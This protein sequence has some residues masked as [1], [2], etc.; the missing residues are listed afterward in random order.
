MAI[1]PTTHTS[2][3][4]CSIDRESAWRAPAIRPVYAA[5]LMRSGSCLRTSHCP[6]TPFDCTLAACLVPAT[7]YGEYTVKRVSNG[8]CENKYRK[9]VQFKDFVI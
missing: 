9:K 4:T 6:C 2:E 8:G 1:L 5:R 7:I 3:S